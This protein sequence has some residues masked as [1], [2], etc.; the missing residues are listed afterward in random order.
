MGLQRVKTRVTNAFT[1]VLE[2]SRASILFFSILNSPQGTLA[3][4]LQWLL[5]IG[6]HNLLFTSKAG[7][8]FCP[9]IEAWHS[10]VTEHCQIPHLVLKKKNVSFLR[11]QQMIKT[12]MVVKYALLSFFNFRLK[13]EVECC[14]C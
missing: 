5:A 2:L 11:G 12:K 7:N 6:W 10:P 13:I 9:Q 8:I 14:S 3:R 1:F 4:W